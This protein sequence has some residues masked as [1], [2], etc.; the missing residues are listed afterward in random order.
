MGIKDKVAFIY[1]NDF[2][3]FIPDIASGSKIIGF[4][5]DIDRTQDQ[6]SISYDLIFFD[7]ITQ[8]KKFK[9][10]FNAFEY[11]LKDGEIAFLAFGKNVKSDVNGSKAYLSVYKNANNKYFFYLPNEDYLL[12]RVIELPELSHELFRT[13]L[14]IDDQE[15]PIPKGTNK[16]IIDKPKSF[17]KKL[18][19][20]IVYFGKESQLII[21]KPKLKVAGLKRTVKD[22]LK[23]A[24]ISIDNKKYSINIEEDEY[25]INKWIDLGN[26]SLKSGNHI[27]SI[28]NSPFFRIASVMMETSCPFQTI[29]ND[30]EYMHKSAI[31]TKFKIYAFKITLFILLLITGYIIKSKFKNIFQKF[32]KKINKFAQ[33]VLYSLSNKAWFNISFLV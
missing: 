24:V 6:N 31:I 16:I 15:I 23:N 17:I 11:W 12:A 32:W 10:N 21:D 2:E 5:K 26:I 19:Y 22:E 28:E 25:S 1:K 3:Y 8:T 18:S 4:T 13:H 27:I 7:V 33:K 20:E 9:F 29:I 14:K 30:K